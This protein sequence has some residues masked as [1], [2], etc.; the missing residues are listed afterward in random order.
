MHN[1]APTQRTPRRLLAANRAGP[2][3]ETRG[4]IGILGY[5]LARMTMTSWGPHDGSSSLGDEDD[6]FGAGNAPPPLA[7]R[8][9][10]QG[11]PNFFLLPPAGYPNILT[12]KSVG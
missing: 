2:D 9:L 4:A 10:S 8:R 1:P 3:A 12:R 11:K 5:A 7:Y 6:L